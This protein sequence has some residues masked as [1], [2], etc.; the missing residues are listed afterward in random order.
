MRIQ[1]YYDPSERLFRLNSHVWLPHPVT[2]VFEFF[3]QAS[4]LETLTPEFLHFQ[5][6]TPQPI[7]MKQGRLIDYSLSLHGIRFRWTSEISVWEPAHRF[8]DRQIRGPYSFWNHEHRFEEQ[9][10]GTLCFDEVRYDV[11]GGR[12]INGMFVQWNLRRVFEYRHKKLLELFGTS[13]LRP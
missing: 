5:I 7:D 1:Q 10:G 9:D 4:N 12:L 6:L 8:V 13:Q 3:S 2:D 11:F